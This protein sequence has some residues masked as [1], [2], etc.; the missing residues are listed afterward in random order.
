[1][2]RTKNLMKKEKGKKKEIKERHYQS[3]L[4]VIQRINMLKQN[5]KLYNFEFLAFS[6]LT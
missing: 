4:N 2:K 6:D 5:T 3:Y 1:M